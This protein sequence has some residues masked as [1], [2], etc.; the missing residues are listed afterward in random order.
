VPHAVVLVLPAAGVVRLAALIARGEPASFSDA[1]DAWHDRPLRTLGLGAVML[2]AGTVLVTNA[3]G[4]VFSTSM[5][6][7]AIATLAT[8][9]LVAGW[10]WLWC[11]WPILLDPRRPE[12]RWQDAARLAGV[13]LLAYP[14]RLAALG[15]TLGILLLLS[16]LAF[17]LLFTVSLAVAALA[18]CRYVLP[19]ADR[20]EAGLAGRAK[21]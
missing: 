4:G 7:W 6:G 16:A 19:A 5:L 9:G 17:L 8:W 18:A 2:L 20:L 12:E 21:S 14:W 13:M 15:L 10:C 1:L 3:V 11:F